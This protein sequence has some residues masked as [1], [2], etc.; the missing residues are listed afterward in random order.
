MTH[1]SD[2]GRK[3]RAIKIRLSPETA[4]KL[5]ALCARDGVTIGAWIEAQVD[6]YRKPVMDRR[7][8]RQGLAA[9]RRDAAGVR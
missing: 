9:A 8:V 1:P 7:D 6:A 4:S 2:I 5:E 3:T